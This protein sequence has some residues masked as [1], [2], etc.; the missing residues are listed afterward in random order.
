MNSTL[1]GKEVF[2]PSTL[3]GISNSGEK[4]QLDLDCAT[5]KVKGTKNVVKTQLSER[6]GSVKE[7]FAVDDYT[8]DIKGVL[9]GH[10]GVLP[11]SQV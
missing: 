9:I 8:I 2:L 6:K 11:C 10:D 7:V 4:I 5:I 1:W 3:V